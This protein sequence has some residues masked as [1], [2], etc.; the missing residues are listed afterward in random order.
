MK[1][2]DK[3]PTLQ[4]IQSLIDRN[5]AV[6][7]DGGLATELESRGHD[8]NDDLW[9][10]RL[11]LSESVAIRDVHLAYLQAGAD[12][13]VTASY[14][15]SIP[16]LTAQGLGKDD[17]MNVL[18]SSVSIARDAAALYAQ[19]S[20]RQVLIAASVGPYGAYLADGSEYHGNYN[21]SRDELFD[22]HGPRLECLSQS[23]AD[24]LAI[25][26]IPNRVE[27]SVLCELVGRA[28]IPAWLSCCCRNERELSDGAELAEVVAIAADYESIFAV[29]ANCTSPEFIP[30]LMESIQR[31]ANSKGIVVYPNSGQRYEIETRSWRG[32]TSE[33]DFGQLAISWK[34]RGATLIGGC[35]KTGPEHIRQVRIA[36][37]ESQSDASDMQS[38]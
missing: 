8:L 11:L 17:A 23:D 10:A 31:A 34:N 14:Q 36:L 19:E 9:S 38:T 35:C 2:I 26:T 22:F 18:L 24:L 16:G 4:V 33:A 27:A 12:C 5:G 29:G 13:I 25:E 30:G 28:D 3:H 37:S 15:A 7:L 21:A 20:E 1:T 32:E 6:I